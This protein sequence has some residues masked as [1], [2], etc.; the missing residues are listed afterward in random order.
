MCCCHFDFSPGLWIWL[1]TG[2]A[3]TVATLGHLAKWHATLTIMVT[4][5]TT[6]KAKSCMTAG[7]SPPT[8][9]CCCTRAICIVQQLTKPLQLQLRWQRRWQ[10]QPTLTKPSKCTSRSTLFGFMCYLALFVAVKMSVRLLDSRSQCA[11]V[12][13]CMAYK[14]IR[15]QQQ[16]QEHTQECKRVQRKQSSRRTG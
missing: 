10:Q 4:T 15:R 1:S 9:S 7:H 2:N 8:E 16:Q 13:R 3:A 5:K 14:G 6:S 11:V 12:N